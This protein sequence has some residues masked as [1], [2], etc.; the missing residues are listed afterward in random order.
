MKN[1]QKTII[2]NILFATAGLALFFLAIFP[3]RNYFINKNLHEGD[4]LMA[5]RKYTEAYVHFQKAQLLSFFNDRAKERAESTK[6]AAKDILKM[7]DFLQEKNNVDLLTLI[8]K[9][10]SKTC[11]LEADKIL[12]EDD[13]SQVAI[14]NLKFCANDGPKDYSSWLFLGAASLQFSENNYIF[15]EQKPGLRKDAISAFEKA[16]AIDPIDKSAIKYLI[17]TN[18]I[19][20]NQPEVDRWQKLLDNLNKIE[21]P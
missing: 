7:Q 5:E 10:D 21:K 19:E 14:I 11:D 1:K 13:L 20:N 15:K 18:K 17:S 12:I 4:E 16:Y 3:L 8:N 2:K 6:E 9:A